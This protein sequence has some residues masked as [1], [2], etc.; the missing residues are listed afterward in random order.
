MPLSNPNSSNGI[1][2]KLFLAT[3]PQLLAIL[4]ALWIF[5]LRVEHRLTAVETQVGSTI[6]QLEVVQKKLDK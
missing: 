2:F 3:L 5:S 1:A 6:T 4:S